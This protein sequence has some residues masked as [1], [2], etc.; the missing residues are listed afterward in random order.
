MLHRIAQ[1]AF[2]FGLVALAWR[3][4]GKGSKTQSAEAPWPPGRDILNDQEVRRR[5]SSADW[6]TV[7]D[8]ARALQNAPEWRKP[9]G[10]A[11]RDAR[12]MIDRWVN[13]RIVRFERFG[14][15]H[16]PFYRFV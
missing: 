9:S 5:L 14:P 3:F 2:A 7:T 16:R 11:G 10:S 15:S 12:T 4:G 6:F 8:V 1:L 13:E